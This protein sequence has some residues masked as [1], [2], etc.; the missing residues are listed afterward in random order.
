MKKRSLGK[1]KFYRRKNIQVQ[2]LNKPVL[3][4]Y[5]VLKLCVTG[6]WIV[7]VG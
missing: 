5:R 6:T 2:I 4:S 1:R 7:V 3:E